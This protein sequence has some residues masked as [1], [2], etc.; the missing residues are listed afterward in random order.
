MLI[1]SIAGCVT[2]DPRKVERKKPGHLKARKKPA[3]VKRWYPSQR[4]LYIYI[5]YMCVSLVHQITHHRP[6]GHYTTSLPRLQNWYCTLIYLSIY[7]GMTWKLVS[8]ASRAGSSWYHL[9]VFPLS[10]SPL[11]P[12]SLSIPSAPFPSDT[13]ISID[14]R[15]KKFWRRSQEYLR[16][17]FFLDEIVLIADCRRG[18][19]VEGTGNYW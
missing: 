19:E 6:F 1:P 10:P 11:L 17:Y 15:S 2:R 7:I 16:F 13:S 12:L 8:A 9:L 18:G 14:I 4:F 5:I 3:W